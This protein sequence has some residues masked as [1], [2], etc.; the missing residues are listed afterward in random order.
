MCCINVIMILLN[1]SL[2]TTWPISAKFHADPTVETGRRVCSNAY[3]PSTVMPI[4]GKNTFFFK[5]KNCS[6]DD[7]FISCNDRIGKNVL[8]YLH[9]CSG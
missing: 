8:H 2:E 5:P 1:N 7:P 4:Y 9:I 6:N 3:A